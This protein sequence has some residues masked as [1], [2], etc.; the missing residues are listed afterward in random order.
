MSTDEKATPNLLV[1]VMRDNTSQ[2]SSHIVAG[3]RARPEGRRLEEWV[4]RKYL[5]FMPNLLTTTHR[6]LAA[7][8]SSSFDAAAFYCDFRAK[9]SPRQDPK[10]PKSQNFNSRA[11]V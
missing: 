1:V 5:N 11:R 9:A 7:P 4:P 3:I 6:S 10:L 2:E 8:D